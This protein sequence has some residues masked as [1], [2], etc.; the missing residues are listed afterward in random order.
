MLVQNYVVT[1][2]NSASSATKQDL[3]S[4]SID[5]LSLQYKFIVFDTQA[6]DIYARC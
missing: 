2:S 5:Y 6:K 1:Q 4:I 3:L